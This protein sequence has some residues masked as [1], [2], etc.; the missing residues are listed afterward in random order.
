MGS[1]SGLVPL[2]KAVAAAW[3]GNFQKVEMTGETP[4]AFAKAGRRL[5][6][7]FASPPAQPEW[8]TIRDK[9][10]PFYSAKAWRLEQAIIQTVKNSS[11][12]IVF[13]E[14]IEDQ[15][16]CLAQERGSW[17][18]TRLVGMSHQAPAWWRS[19]HARP[20]IVS[21]LDLLVVVASGTKSWW[22][23]YIAPE[24][25]H[26]LPHGVDADFFMALPV[27]P[28][29]IARGGSLRVVFSGFWLRDFQTLAKV[30]GL[31]D[32]QNLD[33][34]FDL[35]VPIHARK[36]E[37]CHQLDRSPRVRWHADLSDIELRNAYLQADLLL[38]TLTDSTANNG[39]LE[40][41][42]CG[43][44]AIVTD[45]GGVRDYANEQFADFVRPGDAV[46]II[47]LLKE[48]GADKNRLARRGALARAHVEKHLSWDRVASGFAGILNNLDN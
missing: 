23:Q 40:G 30:V 22:E 21:S 39:L 27:A 35:I 9:W 42:A 32:Q 8:E 47:N 14:C 19:Y 34:T 11:P 18:K 3:D 48:R 25:I 24:K 20:E 46:E 37:G 15:Y 43:L 10:S 13:L 26:F 7:F 29:R 6:K 16:F 36:T 45:V 33:V 1:H 4:A 41:M 28:E 44:P 38:L 2:S 31:A 12:D 5:R 17:H